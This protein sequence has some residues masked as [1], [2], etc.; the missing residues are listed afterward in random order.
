MA[1]CNVCNGSRFVTVDAVKRCEGCGEKFLAA[2]A[3]AEEF[4]KAG[5]AALEGIIADEDLDDVE[6]VTSDGVTHETLGSAL[7]IRDAAEQALD[8]AVVAA[9]DD[10]GVLDEDLPNP[11]AVGGAVAPDEPATP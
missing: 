5:A 4:G 6:F 7:G 11:D 10:A 9:L 3:A 8:P 2:A 1:R